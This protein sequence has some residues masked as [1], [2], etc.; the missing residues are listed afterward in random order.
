[1]SKTARQHVCKASCQI[2]F[3]VLKC[4]HGLHMS[5][6]FVSFYTRLEVDIVVSTV[7]PYNTYVLK[8]LPSVWSSL[9]SVKIAAF[10]TLVS[11]SITTLKIIYKMIG[12][13]SYLDTNPDLSVKRVK[14][15]HCCGLASATIVYLTR[16]YT[17]NYLTGSIYLLITTDNNKLQLTIA[18]KNNWINRQKRIYLFTCLI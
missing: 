15:H 8:V 4:T 11:F 3:F 12:Y 17:Q 7:L 2:L 10:G 6:S 14:K 9:L 16:T 18:T 5:M 1:M 13:L